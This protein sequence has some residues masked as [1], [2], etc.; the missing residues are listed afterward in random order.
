[1]ARPYPLEPHLTR[2]ELEQ[3]YRAARSAVERGRWQILWL[4]ACG[5][6]AQE[7]A[8]VT[9]FGRD[10]V[11]RVAR[12]YNREGPDALADRR[13]HNRGH[14]P[15]LTPEDEAELAALLARPRS[16]G[17][18]W[19]GALVG[20]WIGERVGRPVGYRRGW[21][22]LRKLGFTLQQP[23][24]RHQQADAEAQQAL[25]KT[26][27]LPGGRGRAVVHGRA[28]DRAEA[29]PAAGLGAAG[30]AA[31]GRRATALRVA[32]SVRL[33]PSP[34]GAGVVAEPADGEH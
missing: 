4:L 1:M 31:R 27:A 2:E 25:K 23:R 29:D 10:W 11:Y 32:V 26:P 24:P 33:L 21:V 18:F 16:D 7:V 13:Q 5:R 20:Q 22:Y 17:R 30:P 3:R 19:T 28:P 8:E 34:H 14:P 15:L 12:R 9:G 6:S